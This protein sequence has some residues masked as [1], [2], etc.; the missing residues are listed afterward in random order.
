MDTN[1]SFD[2]IKDGVTQ[3]MS[4]LPIEWNSLHVEPLHYKN[5]LFLQ[6]AERIANQ[7]KPVAQVSIQ[8]IE[9]TTP[10]YN[11]SGNKSWPRLKVPYPGIAKLYQY[12]T[13]AGVQVMVPIEF[14]NGDLVVWRL[15]NDIDSLYPYILMF[16]PRH[17]E[18]QQFSKVFPQYVHIQE[19]FKE[20]LDVTQLYYQL[21]PSLPV[22]HVPYGNQDQDQKRRDPM[23]SLI[24]ASSRDF[25]EVSV[26]KKCG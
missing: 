9:N 11:P 22:V 7:H 1:T 20:G 2:V 17:G 12:A 26:R 15:L 10:L 24:F 19:L 18:A 21:Y 16:R 8:K 13:I 5:F 6:E 3:K 4:G 25:D 23:G 14:K